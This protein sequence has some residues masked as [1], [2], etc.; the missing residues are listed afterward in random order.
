MAEFIM[1]H[2]VHT[3]GHDEDFMIASAAAT[4]DEIGSDIYPPAQRELRKH[5]IPFEHRGARILTSSEYDEWDY[6]IVMD[7]ENVY[8]VMYILGDDPEGKVRLLLSFTGEERQISD[9]WFTRDFAAAY[10]D[11]YE[12]CSAL[13]EHILSGR[14]R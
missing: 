3:S 2:L 14:K 4:Y 1:K 7:R 5:N 10:N 11:I 8:D 13:L 12:G 6:I 9:P